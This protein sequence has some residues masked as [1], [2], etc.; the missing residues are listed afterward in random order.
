M[1]L[2]GRRLHRFSIKLSL[3]NRIRNVWWELKFKM[4]RYHIIIYFFWHMWACI[5]TV[6]C[7]LERKSVGDYTQCWHVL[8]CKPYTAFIDCVYI[9]DIHTIWWHVQNMYLQVPC[10]HIPR[11]NQCFIF[12]CNM[13]EREILWSMKVPDTLISD[14][15]WQ[16]SHTRSFIQWRLII[17]NLRSSTCRL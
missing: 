14:P 7:I 11:V 1:P 17:E 5:H 6:A 4:M 13:R 16:F 3:F 15:E 2:Y 10:I 9:H 12:R 8:H